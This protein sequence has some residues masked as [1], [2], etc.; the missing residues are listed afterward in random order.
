M[1][2]RTAHNDNLFN[3][4]AICHRFAVSD[5]PGDRLVETAATAMMYAAHADA[6]GVVLRAARGNTP[7]LWAWARD[8]IRETRRILGYIKD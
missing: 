8:E 7:E 6:H 4:Q 1:T 2:D 5:V 3:A